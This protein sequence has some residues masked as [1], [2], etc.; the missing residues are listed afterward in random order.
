[1]QWKENEINAIDCIEY[2]HDADGDGYG[3]TF[4]P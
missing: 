4:Y 1:M 2:H 3:G